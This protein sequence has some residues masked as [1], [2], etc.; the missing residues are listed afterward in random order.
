MCMKLFALVQLTGDCWVP[1]DTER[2]VF[3]GPSSVFILFVKLWE[4]YY[5]YCSQR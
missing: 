5:A 3:P 4:V 2:A 1:P